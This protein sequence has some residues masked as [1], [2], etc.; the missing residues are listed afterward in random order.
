MHRTSEHVR[1]NDAIRGVR[2]GLD[3]VPGFHA[4]LSSY[5]ATLR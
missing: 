2:C 4:E 5:P 3:I 1:L